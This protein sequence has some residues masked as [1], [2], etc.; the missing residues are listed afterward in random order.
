MG[1]KVN[2]WLLEEGEFG[3]R[4]GN[5]NWSEPESFLM[6]R[7]LKVVRIGTCSF[8]FSGLGAL[9]GTVL[10]IWISFNENQSWIC[11]AVLPPV[12]CVIVTANSNYPIVYLIT[13]GAPGDRRS[14]FVIINRSDL[15]AVIKLCTP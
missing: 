8:G 2:G 10:W 5:W 3:R 4:E 15:H 11:W 13:S 9:R 6:Y 1:G 14:L 7:G 12:M